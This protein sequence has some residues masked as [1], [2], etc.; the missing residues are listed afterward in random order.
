MHIREIVAI[1]APTSVLNAGTVWWQLDSKIDREST[2]PGAKMERLNSLLTDNL[3]LL[4]RDIGALQ[5][6]SHT[7]TP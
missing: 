2:A 4:N 6:A 7:Q 5:D 3:M 1:T